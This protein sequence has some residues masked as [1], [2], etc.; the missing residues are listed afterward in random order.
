[1]YLRKR[2]HHWKLVVASKL[3][4]V[5]PCYNEE[6]VIGETADR[7]DSL[8]QSLVASG[9]VS[10][11][12]YAIYVDDGSRDSTWEKII[13]F[14]KAG[15]PI[16]GVKLTRNMGH[17][18]ALMAGLLNSDGD[19]TISIDADLQ[20]DLNAVVDMLG[21]YEKGSQIVYGV[22]ENRSTDT[23]FK[24]LT[25]RWFYSLMQRMGVETIPDHADYRLLSRQ[26]LD[27][28]A[29]FSEANLYLRGLIPMVGFKSSVVKYVRAERFAGTSKYPIRKM[30]GLA[31][32]AITSF[33]VF[34]LRLISVAGVLLSASSFLVS[35]WVLLAALFTSTQAGWA[36]TALPI[37]FI[38]GL[39]LL[40]LGI[41][42]EY[43]GRIY[44][45]TKRRPRFLV[46]EISPLPTSQRT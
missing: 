42:G 40:G 15:M 1:L 23:Q 24:R 41:V 3:V 9:I 33:S 38:G 31:L 27:A 44:L 45:E 28:L 7:L 20:D 35:I 16:K 36:S 26:A 4:F 22:R 30:L 17:Q 46:E 25:A 6:E 43:V 34:P 39:Q 13:G 14:S 12:S 2:D 29:Q 37:Y 5:V 19:I 21:E 11:E 10:A 8:L 18:N 32:V